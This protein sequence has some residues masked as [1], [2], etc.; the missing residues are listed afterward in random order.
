MAGQGRARCPAVLRRLLNHACGPWHPVAVLLG[1][2]TSSVVL[3]PLRYQFGAVLGEVY[4]DNW[5]VIAGSVA[6]PQGSWSFGKW[7]VAW[8]SE[9]GG[10]GDRRK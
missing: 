2:H 1:D 9:T 6:T 8:G 5:L 10:A 4:D 3:C 7:S